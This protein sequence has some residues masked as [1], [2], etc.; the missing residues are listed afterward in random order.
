M[1]SRLKRHSLQSSGHNS[2]TFAFILAKEI[3]EASKIDIKKFRK[4]LET[5]EQFKP[6]YQ[7]QKDRVSRMKIKTVSIDN[8]V[9]QTFFE[10][11]AAMELKTKYNEWGTH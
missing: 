1:R 2:A 5:D 10:V 3:A 7:A 4:N 6:I 8:A 11:Y 9:E